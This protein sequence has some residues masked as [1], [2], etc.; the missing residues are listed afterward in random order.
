[1]ETCLCFSFIKNPKP[2]ELSNS[3]LSFFILCKRNFSCCYCGRIYLILFC[4]YRERTW[5][6]ILG[7]WFSYSGELLGNFYNFVIISHLES[8]WLIVLFMLEL[9]CCHQRSFTFLMM[10]MKDIRTTL[11]NGSHLLFIFKL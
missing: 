5:G 7:K 11:L 10:E 1:M 3:L 8:R 2:P 4:F 6:W 9:C